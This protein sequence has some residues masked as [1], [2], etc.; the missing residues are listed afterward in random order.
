MSAGPGC[1]VGGGGLQYTCPTR[2]NTA[3]DIPL[4]CTVDRGKANQSFENLK[5][6][7][8]L[9]ISPTKE[10][11]GICWSCN[12][13]SNRRGEEGK[14]K[15]RKGGKRRGPLLLL[16]SQFD[17]ISS[18]RKKKK[19]KLDVSAKEGLREEKKGRIESFFL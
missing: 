10:K 15:E 2:Q 13:R 12:Y 6:L 14:G 16:M 17:Y 18:A 5:G 7:Q 11:K 1:A 4:T 8:R 3:G 19:K 9:V